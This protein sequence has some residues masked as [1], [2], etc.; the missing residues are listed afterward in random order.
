MRELGAP[1]QVAP[2]VQPTGPARGQR[3][4]L[5][6][7]VFGLFFVWGGVTSL[8]DVLIPKLKG[9][10]SLSYV[11]AMLSQF[12]FFMAYFLVSIPAGTL[13]SKVGYVRGL[14]LGLGV[15]VLGALLFWPAAS[16]GAYWPFLIALFVLAA[17]ITVL[18]VAANPLIATLGD[19]ATASSRLT[20]AQAFNSLGT[21]LWPYLGALLLL[22]ANGAQ[23]TRSTATTVSDIYLVI[24]VV[25]AAI[26]LVFWS[27]RRVLRTEFP[28][29]VGFFD[30]LAL[31]KQRRML[32]GTLA[33]F[34]YV[35]AEVSIG[36]ILVNYLEQAS[37]LHLDA[38]RAG[39]RLSFYWGGAMV[40]RFIGS[41]LL[42]RANPGTLLAVFAGSAGALVV[43]SMVTTGW[44]SGWS[45][46][47]VGLFNSIMF[48]TIFSLALEGQ[49][50][51][52]PQASGV[53]CMAIVGGALVPL[54]TGGVAD[55]TSAATALLVPV[56][57]YALVAAFGVSTRRPQGFFLPSPRPG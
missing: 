20:F 39:Q 2:L 33:L 24:A 28:E 52:T 37:T 32:F 44:I 17:G 15:M 26:A 12:A 38:Q 35:G 43:S 6:W 1:Q 31:L 14:V 8:N 3:A 57:C 51:R 25:L 18:Q 9:L 11:E 53:L 47:A 21:T 42:E 19:P 40:G 7:L 50:A 10:F 13:I 45:L 55:A 36:S 23:E 22:D 5:V 34:M 46:I 30:S 48:P 56:V 29:A 54:L 4:A 49:G 41:W 27:R 16:S